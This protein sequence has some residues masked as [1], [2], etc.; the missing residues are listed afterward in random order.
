MSNLNCVCF[1][2]GSFVFYNSERFYVFDGSGY[3]FVID[4][5]F[6]FDVVNL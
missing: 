5:L 3:K 1:V 4:Y 2:I 6:K